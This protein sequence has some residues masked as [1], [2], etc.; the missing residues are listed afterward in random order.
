[1]HSYTTSI[2]INVDY[3]V[4]TLLDRDTVPR[5]AVRDLETRRVDRHEAVVHA[6]KRI[7]TRGVHGPS[8][9]T[10]VVPQVSMYRMGHDVDRGHRR[11]VRHV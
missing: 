10:T 1:M 2:W 3:V 4:T 11:D 7:Q 5:R 6:C 8:P 9:G